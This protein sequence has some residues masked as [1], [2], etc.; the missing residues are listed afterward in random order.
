MDSQLS[1]MYYKRVDIPFFFDR[2]MI[3]ILNIFFS[4]FIILIRILSFS[5]TLFY[6]QLYIAYN[7]RAP[8]LVEVP[9]VVFPADRFVLT[10]CA[11]IALICLKFGPA[12]ILGLLP[13]RGAC[14]KGTSGPR[15]T[16]PAGCLPK[17]LVLLSWGHL[18]SSPP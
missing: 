7:F 4:F 5:F 10:I 3:T 1:A 14:V 17:L 12:C 9:N 15:L 8:A 16:F 2:D 6:L 13:K 18:K 11:P